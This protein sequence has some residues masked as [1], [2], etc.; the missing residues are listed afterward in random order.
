M[1]LILRNQAIGT[2]KLEGDKESWSDEDR[3]FIES[4]TTQAALALENIRLVEETRRAAQHDRILAD[5]TTQVWATTD[6]EMIL[7]T[8][9]RQLGQTLQASDGIIRLDTSQEFGNPDQE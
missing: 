9:I 3:S 5:I 6:M 1:P 8:A 7:Q 2:I 4:V